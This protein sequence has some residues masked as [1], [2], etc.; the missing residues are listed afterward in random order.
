M[1][2]NRIQQLIFSEFANKTVLAVIHRMD[3]IHDFDRVILVSDGA[4]IENDTPQN[5]FA[6][7]SG[8]RN[9]ARFIKATENRV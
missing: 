9:F 5:L 7:S 6:K 4:I 3:S 2:Q 8:F 1:T